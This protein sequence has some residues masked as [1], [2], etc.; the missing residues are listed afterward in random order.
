M[1]FNETLKE[2]VEF[3]GYRVDIYGRVYNKFGD[4]LKQ[5]INHGGYCMVMLSRNGYR[6]NCLVH[7]L[8]ATAF[9]GGEFKGLEV[10]HIDCNK[11]NN[12]VGNLEWVSKGDNLRH[13]Y[14]HGLRES[15][16]THDDQKMGAYISGDRSRR[17]VLVLETGETYPSVRSCSNLL[18]LDAS[19]VSR[20]C[21][22]L[23]SQHHG[24]HF[25]FVDE[26]DF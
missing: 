25:R 15:Y 13:A 9:L 6:R 4:E 24:Y 17:A 10:N 14:S 21:N 16:L 18:G 26:E 23:A 19:A 2:I 3:P 11:Q 22:G 20:C 12:F 5:T 8:V 7:R 1:N